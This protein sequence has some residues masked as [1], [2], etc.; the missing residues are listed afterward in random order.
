MSAGRRDAPRRRTG[1]H[2]RRSP[3]G[4]FDHGAQEPSRDASPARRRPATD[5]P[6]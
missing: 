2:R 6:P 4:P 5:K 1:R 3:A